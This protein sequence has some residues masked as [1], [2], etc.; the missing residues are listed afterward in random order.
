MLEFIINAEQRISPGGKLNFSEPITGA[1]TLNKF[2]GMGI[3]P[4]IA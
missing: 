3:R 2:A 1:E 4:L